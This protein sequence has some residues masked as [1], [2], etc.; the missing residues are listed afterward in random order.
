VKLLYEHYRRLGEG[1]IEDLGLY[2]FPKTVMS[3]SV[4]PVPKAA[5][6]SGFHEKHRNFLSSARFDPGT[7]CTTGKHATT[8]TYWYSSGTE[9]C[10]VVVAVASEG[11]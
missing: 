8:A 3:V 11:D 1:M 7:S 2:T 10:G 5:Y 6:R 4:Q 9:H